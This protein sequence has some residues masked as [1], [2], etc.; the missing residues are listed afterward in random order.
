MQRAKVLVVDD[1]PSVLKV[2]A[3]ALESRG[4]E[5]IAVDDAKQ[6]LNIVEK[7][8]GE[9]SVV[10]SDVRM[11]GMSGPQLIRKVAERSPV[12]AVAL[13]SGDIGPE[14]IEPQIPVI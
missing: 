13:M 6:A 2:V 4:L 11:P 9:I 14:I 1:E 7:Q 10:L 5:V 3:A 12:I 8:G